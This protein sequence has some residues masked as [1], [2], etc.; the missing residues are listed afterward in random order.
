M[1]ISREQVARN[2]L[3]ITRYPAGMCA[4]F[5]RECAGF[6]A[7]GDFDNDGDA[8][9]V[10][11]WKAT[12][13]RHEGDRH[14]PLGTIAFWGGGSKGH[15]HAAPVVT[16]DGHVRSTDQQR[17]GDVSTVPLGEIERDWPGVHYLGWTDAPY[18]NP[19]RSELDERLGSQ[20]DKWRAKRAMLKLRLARARAR[21]KALKA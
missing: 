12:T 15:G 3:K 11:M 13:D 5:S 10:D 1:T 20:I 8:D 17:P 14:P 19:I 16:E 6:G 18:G 9:A 2:A 21:R 4:R 7:L